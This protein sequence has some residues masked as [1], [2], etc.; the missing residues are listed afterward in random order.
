MSVS[1]CTQYT[2]VIWVWSKKSSCTGIVSI[3]TIYVIEANKRTCAVLTFLQSSFITK[4]IIARPP[5]LQHGNKKVKD[6][7][8]NMVKVD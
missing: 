5:N 1:G 2:C 8:M 3:G 4:F 7:R 6:L